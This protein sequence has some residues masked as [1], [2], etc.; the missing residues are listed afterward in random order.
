MSNKETEVKQMLHE[1]PT[2]RTAPLDHD[3][4]KHYY[5]DDIENNQEGEEDGDKENS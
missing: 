2:P 5:N 3:W 4:T 1:A